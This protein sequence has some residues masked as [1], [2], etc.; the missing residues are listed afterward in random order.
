MTPASPD[1]LYPTF[2]AVFERQASLD[3]ALQAAFATQLGDQE[4]RAHRDERIRMADA[5]LE[6]IASGMDPEDRRRLVELEVVLTSSATR[7]SFEVL[8]GASPG[9]AADVVAW[10][11]RGLAR[12][13][14]NS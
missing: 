8:L 9:R 5:W 12:A 11:I 7:H 3:P 2:R 13:S 10:A 1:D 6:S 14:G 4:R